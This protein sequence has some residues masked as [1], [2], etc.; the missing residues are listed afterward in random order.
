MFNS[1]I[2]LRYMVPRS[3][4][5]GLVVLTA[6]CS[7]APGIDDSRPVEVSSQRIDLPNK[8]V[9]NVDEWKYS[10][11]L[12]SKHDPMTDKIWE[13]I[14]NKAT[15]VSVEGGNGY[16]F[17]LRLH[18]DAGLKLDTS[19]R[20]GAQRQVTFY[21]EHGALAPR[22][23]HRNF[24]HLRVRFDRRPPI[25]Y[26]FFTGDDRN[27]LE[28]LGE[29]EAKTFHDDLTRSKKMLIEFE[30]LPDGFSSSQSQLRIVEFNVD[31]F[32]LGMPGYGPGTTVYVGGRRMN[33]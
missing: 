24:C 18:L 29:A 27:Y 4:V 14:T 19:T 2:G 3:L 16:I 1:A 25:T 28:L 21:L 7:P 13:I 23:C 26:S 22:S 15:R 9:E 10:S 30:F 8:I 31:S 12:E 33:R 17:G 32:D 11:V 20:K 5:L 6:A